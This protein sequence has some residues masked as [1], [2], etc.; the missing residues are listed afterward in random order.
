MDMKP[1]AALGPLS[2]WEVPQRWFAHFYAL[3]A[4]WNAAVSA[5]FLASPHFRT[6][7]LHAAAAHQAAL[8]LLQLH[9]VRRLAETLGVMRY[10]PGASMHGV[11]YLFGIRQEVLSSMRDGCTSAPPASYAHSHRACACSLAPVVGAPPLGAGSEI[12]ARRVA[13]P[14]PPPVLC[15]AVLC[16]AVLCSY[17]LVVPL[18]ALPAAAYPSMAAT[19]A[20]WWHG[21]P[22]SLAAALAPG[23]VALCLAPLQWTVRG[24]AFPPRVPPPERDSTSRFHL[25]EGMR[26]V[27]LL[28]RA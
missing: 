10:P 23:Q 12:P 14:P 8:A 18:T 27:P 1:P 5:L 15:C 22:Q 17:Y 26:A 16:C 28:A 24:G 9:L 7:P 13:P 6:L 3:G 4:A 11:A 25:P 20:A 2:D 21:A 19:L